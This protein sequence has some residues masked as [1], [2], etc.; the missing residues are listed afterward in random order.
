MN[1]ST[2]RDTI[3]I[4]QFKLAPGMLQRLV[5]SNSEWLVHI[6]AS[7]VS[8]EVEAFFLRW[9]SEAHPVTRCLLSGGAV[10]FAGSYPGAQTMAGNPQVTSSAGASMELG[11]ATIS[12]QSAIK[13]SADRSMR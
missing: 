3:K 4:W 12:G 8:P 10:V 9:H 1:E 2:D 6:P 13:T 11:T 5:G 7:F